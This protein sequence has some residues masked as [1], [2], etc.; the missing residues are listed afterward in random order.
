MID[1]TFRSGNT[2][3]LDRLARFV[4]RHPRLFVLT[5]AGV[6]TASGIP[7]Y[8]DHDGQWKHRQPVCY[9][10]FLR[11]ERMR[12]RYWARSLIGWP[13]FAQARPNAAHRALAHL[14]SMGYVQ[15]LVTQNV[16]RLH[17]QAGSARVIDL[18]GRLDRVECLHCGQALARATFQQSLQALNPQFN[19]HKAT[20]TPDGD[21]DW[22]ETDLSTFRVPGCRECGG[23]LKPAVVFFGECVPRRTVELV[24]RHLAEAD[25]IVTV[26]SS[27]MVYSAYRFCRAAVEQ[28]KPVAV[29]NL[30]R[31]R[32]D[33]ELSLKVIGSC[34][35]VLGELVER[36]APRAGH[37]LAGH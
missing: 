5:G 4:E 21:A 18:H 31:T 27:L 7:D 13:R 34:A 20:M 12:Q 1:A 28:G 36:L 15:H 17:Q 26:G 25:A 2:D 23:V 9:Q 30:G 10:E 35:E 37:G 32:I 29:V 11:Y 3:A 33:A 16:D 19:G 6:S 22:A 8:R 24:Y 14:E